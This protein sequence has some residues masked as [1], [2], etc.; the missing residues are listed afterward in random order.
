MNKVLLEKPT[1][2]LPPL[3]KASGQNCPF[4]KAFGTNRVKTP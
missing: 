4:L 2:Q 1:A 3:F